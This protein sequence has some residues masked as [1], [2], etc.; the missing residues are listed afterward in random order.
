MV[1]QFTD[2]TEINT[3][4]NNIHKITFTGTEM[5]IKLSDGDESEYSMEDIAKIKFSSIS[6]DTEK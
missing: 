4:I 5:N 1:L 2:N 3:A 6:D